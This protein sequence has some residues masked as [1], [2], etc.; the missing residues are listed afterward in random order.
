MVH[1]IF[2]FYQTSGACAGM[3]MCDCMHQMEKSGGGDNIVANGMEQLKVVS[4]NCS[5]R[6]GSSDSNGT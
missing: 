3:C 6:Y 5:R 1:A 4:Q 2:Y